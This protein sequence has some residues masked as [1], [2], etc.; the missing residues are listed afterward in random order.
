MVARKYVWLTITVGLL[1]ACAEPQMPKAYNDSS[2]YTVA[3]DVLW[4]SPDGFD[5]T[6]DIYT[7]T[8]G[9]ASYPVL[10]IFHGGGWLIMTSR[11]WIKWLSTLPPTAVMWS[12][13]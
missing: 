6:M 1:F 8:S 3:K 9:Q 5:P 11:S 12:A 2:K 7:P 4:A 13:M 10:M